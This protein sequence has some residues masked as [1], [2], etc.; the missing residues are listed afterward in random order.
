M[1]WSRFLISAVAGLFGL[2]GWLTFKDL[3]AFK[4]SKAVAFAF[5]PGQLSKSHASL[6]HQCTACHTPNQGV[7]A[8]GCITCHANNADLL[9]RQPTAFHATISSCKECHQEHRGGITPPLVMDHQALAK[10]GAA[11]HAKGTVT[12]ENQ[13]VRTYLNSK[14]ISE[15]AAK[16]ISVNPHEP[17]IV[18]S[19]NCV[20]CHSTRDKH[21]GYFG[22]SCLSCHGT[23]SWQIAGYKHPPANSRACAQCHQAPPSHYMMHFEMVSKKA[24]GV[25]HANVN[26]CFLC[27]QTTSWNDIKGRGWY[28]HH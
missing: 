23:Q 2:V 12:A 19:L 28:K 4:N 15:V 11:A 26:Q 18:S 3:H 27:H 20:S 10:L 17:P 22:T 21:Q 13:L 16:V 14:H 5:M 7:S 1:M 25:E 9:Q 24:A 6:E 8:T